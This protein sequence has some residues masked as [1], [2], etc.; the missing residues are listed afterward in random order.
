MGNVLSSL[1]FFIVALGILITV[2]EFG[3]YWVARKCG[4]KVLRFSIGFGQPLWS[5]VRGEDKTEYVLAAI[6]LGGYVKMLDEREGEVAPEEVHRAFNRQ[7]LAK[8][9]AIVLAGPVANFI[10]AICAYWLIFVIGVT[11]MKPI[12][13]PVADDSIAAAAGLQ[14]GDVIV[15]VGDKT[16]PT[17][18]T[19]IMAM[20]DQ[21]LD[22]GEVVLRVQQGG[23]SVAMDK[24]LVFPGGVPDDLNRGGFLDFVGVRPSRPAIEPYIGRLAPGGPAETAGIEVGDLVVAADGQAIDDWE[25]WVNYVRARPE[26]PI[27]LE[28][29]RDGARLLLS[30]TPERTEANGEV[31]GRIGAGVKM[32]DMPEDLKAVVQYGPLDSLVNA[33]VKTWEMSFLT[34]RMMGKMVTGDISLSNLSGPISI[35]RYAGY[36]ASIGFVSF[37]TFLAV[38]SISLGV[39]NLLPIPMLDG[40]HLMYYFVEWIKG[41]PVSEQVQLMGQKIGIAMLLSLMVLAFYNDI[42]RLFGY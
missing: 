38:V 27:K 6:P 39:L 9:V 40:G 30:M 33:T 3:H 24:H 14:S 32:K 15:A 42:I 16:T 19:T 11:G 23:S 25:E 2:H 10:L 13:G 18:E 36:S 20:L 17:W 26:Q 5:R 31:F 34:L 41:S 1:F 12:I 4:V 29:E 8:R 21:S 35:A 28:V 22:G 7:S 37:L